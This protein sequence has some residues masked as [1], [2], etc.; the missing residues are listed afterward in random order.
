MRRTTLVNVHIGS[1]AQ[2]KD[3]GDGKSVLNFSV[4]DTEHY[5]K[6]GIKVE[7]TTWIECKWFMKT[8]SAT[9]MAPHLIKGKKMYIEGKSEARAYIK[10]DKAIAVDSLL[11]A[12]VEFLDKKDA[13]ATTNTSNAA[14]AP[15]PNPLPAG[16]HQDDDLPF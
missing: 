13:G 12:S 1:D 2:L 11:V 4:A 3:F 8:E 9:K 10:E 7:K 16:T 5:V 14:S 6:D 15:Q